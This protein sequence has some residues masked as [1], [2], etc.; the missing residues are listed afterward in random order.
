MRCNPPPPSLPLLGAI[1]ALKY[2][3]KEAKLGKNGQFPPTLRAK[4]KIR[5]P[6]KRGRIYVPVAG[7]MEA[8]SLPQRQEVVTTPALGALIVTGW[9][10]FTC[11]LQ[12]K[13]NN[14]QLRLNTM[15]LQSS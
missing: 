7:A 6:P 1:F 11:F 8:G 13:F 15:L 9:T 14:F 5:N 12:A 2:L 10:L 4:V 3:R